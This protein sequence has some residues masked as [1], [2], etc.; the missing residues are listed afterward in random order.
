MS[1]LRNEKRIRMKTFVNIHSSPS[2]N[3]HRPSDPFSH[4]RIILLTRSTRGP[5]GPAGYAQLSANG[6]NDVE[7][8]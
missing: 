1:F 8:F 4:D 2:I 7:M 3:I 5:T 6:K